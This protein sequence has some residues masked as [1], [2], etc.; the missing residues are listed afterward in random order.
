MVGTAATTMAMSDVTMR[1]VGVDLAPR[2]RN[3]MCVSCVPD[4]DGKART[5]SCACGL[6]KGVLTL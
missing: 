4:T 1:P 2:C 6:A 5:K 3:R